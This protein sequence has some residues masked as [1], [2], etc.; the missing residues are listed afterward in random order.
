MMNL[1]QNQREIA[2]VNIWTQGFI[3]QANV[4]RLSLYSG[5]DFI[6]SAG[7]VHYDLIQHEQAPDGSIYE[8]VLADGNVPLTYQIVA[9]WGVDDQPIFDFVAQELQLTLI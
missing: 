3:Y 5:Y 7:Q 9:N 2:P 4:L 6:A 1:Q 8:T